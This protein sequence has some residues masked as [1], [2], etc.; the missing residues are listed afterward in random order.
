[1]LLRR[2]KEHNAFSLA[3][4]FID[5]FQPESPSCRVAIKDGLLFD[6]PTWI[7]HDVEKENV[8]QYWAHAIWSSFIESFSDVEYCV[9][10]SEPFSQVCTDR[11]LNF[12]QLNWS[13]RMCSAT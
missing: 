12:G 2:K 10:E 3:D 7:N 6:E 4:D 8:N 5:I 9:F 13:T 11:H 1:M